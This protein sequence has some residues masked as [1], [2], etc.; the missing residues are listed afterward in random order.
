MAGA[1]DRLVQ[2]AIVNSGT[3]WWRLAARARRPQFPSY[4]GYRHAIQSG[5]L[6]RTSALIGCSALLVAGTPDAQ[7]STLTWTGAATG[8]YE[9][10][11]NWNP[12]TVPGA[13][14]SAL[15]G[16]TV[17]P[18]IQLS[19]PDIVS[20]WTF[21]AGASAYSLCAGHAQ[22]LGGESPLPNLMEVKG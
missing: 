18:N 10:A 4:R 11:A 21:D 17:R 16:A 7:A 13:T 9:S 2:G 8:D 6:L 19:G 15:F 20:G 22:Q 3:P 1:E 5:T 12:G 14:D